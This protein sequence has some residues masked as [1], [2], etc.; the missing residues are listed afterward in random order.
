MSSRTNCADKIRIND[1]SLS[2]LL[3]GGA[4]WESK[5]PKRQPILLSL[6]VTF[7]IRK[8]AETDALPDTIN[9]SSIS[10]EVTELLSA[11]CH[12]S[13]ETLSDS[14]F[15]FVFQSR[16]DISRLDVKI[17]Q[18]RAPLHTKHVGFEC[19]RTRGTGSFLERYFVDDL[20]CPTIVGVN[21][22]ERNERQDVCLN[23]SFERSDSQRAKGSFDYR[24][25]TRIIYDVRQYSL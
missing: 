17:I 2:V 21:I 12:D 25:L 3:E 1:L 9:Y 7:D 23:L 22:C 19:S 11:G 5:V 24:G 20:I 15:N 16:P 6:T 14:I 8:V 13:L 18:T 10:S 4:C